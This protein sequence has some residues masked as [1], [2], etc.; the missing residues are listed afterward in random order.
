M[1]LT[2]IYWQCRRGCLEL[3][4]LLKQYLENHY[5][6][7]TPQQKKTF[8]QLLQLEDDVLLPALLVFLDETTQ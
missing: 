4:L 6:H 3:D 8:L 2:Q 7:A 1:K 5:A